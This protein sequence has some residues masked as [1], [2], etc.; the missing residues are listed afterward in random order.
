VNG[1]WDVQGQSQVPFAGDQDPV[2][3]GAILPQRDRRGKVSA[4]G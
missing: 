3:D 1:H 4:I 2:Q